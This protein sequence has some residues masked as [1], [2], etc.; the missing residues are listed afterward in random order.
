VETTEDL[1][2]CTKHPKFA[3]RII[4]VN[5]M[6]LEI[7]EKLAEELYIFRRGWATSDLIL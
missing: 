4:L 5:K 3:K 6:T 2:C 1:Q 7:K